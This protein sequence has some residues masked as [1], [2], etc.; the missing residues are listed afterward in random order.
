MKTRAL[1]LIPIATLA[2][3]IAQNA[4]ADDRADHCIQYGPRTDASSTGY[5][6]QNLCGTYVTFN[7]RTQYG[8]DDLNLRPTSSTNWTTS[9]FDSWFACRSKG[10]QQPNTSCAH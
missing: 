2:L 1:A 9:R 8:I 3:T 7:I 5:F 10:Y 6:V 4:I